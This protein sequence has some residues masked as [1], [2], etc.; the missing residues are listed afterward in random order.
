MS[1]ELEV[2]VLNVDLDEMEEKIKLIGGILIS[3]ES[4]INTL[5]DSDDNYIEEE[6]DGYLRIRETKDKISGDNKITLTLKKNLQNKKLRENIE[7]NTEISDK[8]SMLK[9]LELLGYKVKNEGYKERTS[10]QIDGVRFD[11]DRWDKE[12]YPYPYM[13]IEVEDE[14]SLDLVVNM[15]DIK[16][17][18]I[19][20]K[21]ISELRKEI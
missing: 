14:E 21:S 20:L 11:L 12:T 13:E 3:E 17:E 15:L 5:I 18:D 10:Y 6:V 16:K 8:E 9:T 19:S 4:Q 1:R 7:I 2:K